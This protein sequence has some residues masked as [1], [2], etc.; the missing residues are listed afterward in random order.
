MLA[1]RVVVTQTLSGA[2][3]ASRLED[4][5]IRTF[6][7]T[8]TR[9]VTHARR[10]VVK[11]Y[12][13]F[14]RYLFAWLPDDGLRTAL[15]VRGCVDVLRRAGSTRMAIVSDAVLASLGEPVAEAVHVGD[16][17][18]VLR[19]QWKDL[20]GTVDAIENARVV[21]LYSMLGAQMKL[22]FPMRDVAQDFRV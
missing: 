2:A 18:R 21:L 3:V 1:A 14:S 4:R 17:V 13:L 9:E 5:G 16:T 6:I 8:Y 19:G 7:P 20:R 10:T 11:T 22:P 12:P 15:S